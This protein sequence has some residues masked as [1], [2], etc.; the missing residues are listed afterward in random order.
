MTLEEI[1]ACPPPPLPNSHVGIDFLRKGAENQCLRESD[2]KVGTNA[3]LQLRSLPDA[4]FLCRKDIGVHWPT[5]AQAVPLLLS[6][7]GPI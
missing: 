7:L 5:G 3:G 1:P 4:K 2:V 6:I